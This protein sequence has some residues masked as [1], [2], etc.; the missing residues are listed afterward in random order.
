MKR[1]T[2][3]KIAKCLD[4]FCN[5]KSAFD[6]KTQRC[7]ICISEIRKI[8]YVKF[9]HRDR[10]ATKA[11]ALNN[12][13]KLKTYREKHNKAYYDSNKSYFIN[14]A[15]KNKEIRTKRSAEWAK[16]NPEIRASR[17]AY[18]RA[19][20]LKATPKWADLEAIEQ[21]YLNCPKGWHVDHIYPLQGKYQ[22]GLHVLENLQY[23]PAIE[24]LRKSNKCDI[25]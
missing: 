23:L 22:S 13:E 18:R 19:K 2:R 4:D 14:Y 16:T 20:Q 11:W 15:N 7:K 6:S 25:I 1:C 17:Q 24:N 12:P 21:F 3:C 9:K 5:D 10:A 8:Q